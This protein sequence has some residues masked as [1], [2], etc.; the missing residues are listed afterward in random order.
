MLRPAGACLGGTQIL[1]ERALATATFTAADAGDPMLVAAKLVVAVI[2][3][4]HAAGAA[5]L[6]PHLDALPSCP[7]LD[8]RRDELARARR[9][10]RSA[11]AAAAAGLPDAELNRLLLAVCFNAHSVDTAAATAEHHGGRCACRKAVLLLLGWVGVVLVLV[12]VLLLVLVLVRVL[13]LVLVLVMP[14]VA[15]VGLR[16]RPVQRRCWHTL[17][18]TFR[19]MREKPP[20]VCMRAVA[21]ANPRS[22]RD[23]P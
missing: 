22:K 8:A 16:W 17:G 14:M 19:C 7:A 9:Y 20:A 18:R 2:A 13:V 23:L 4:G 11:V 1:R 3:G 10:I 5:D 21:L 12:L 15:G 6:H